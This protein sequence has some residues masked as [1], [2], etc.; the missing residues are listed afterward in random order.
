M[1]IE[2]KRLSTSEVTLKDKL[3]NTKPHK[4]QHSMDL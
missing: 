1:V 4:T 3:S 2:C